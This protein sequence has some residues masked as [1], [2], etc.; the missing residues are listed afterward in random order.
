MIF[1][2]FHTH[3]HRT[4][5]TNESSMF[6]YISLI[7]SFVQSWLGAVCIYLYLLYIKY[8]QSTI[9][10]A[11]NRSKNIGIYIDKDFLL[12][13]ALLWHKSLFYLTWCSYIYI[14]RVY[15]LKGVKKVQTKPTKLFLV[16]LHLN[17]STSTENKF[18]R[19]SINNFRAILT[20][21]AVLLC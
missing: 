18:I 7:L 10:I 20:S 4:Q 6:K 3:S 11:I 5:Q 16:L 9:Y 21:A 17:T 15:A 12:T 19:V 14:G 8:I 13:C 2:Q 1:I